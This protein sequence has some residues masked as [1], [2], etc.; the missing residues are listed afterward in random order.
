MI[1]SGTSD[2]TVN[3]R[4]DIFSLD[5]DHIDCSIFDLDIKLMFD[6]SDFAL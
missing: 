6:D 4:Q 5:P 2:T 3:A 1:S